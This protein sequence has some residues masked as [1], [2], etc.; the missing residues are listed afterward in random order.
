MFLSCFCVVAIRI[1]G[2][3]KGKDYGKGNGTPPLPPSR[4]DCCFCRCSSSSPAIGFF[5]MASIGRGIKKSKNGRGPGTHVGG[6]CGPGRKAHGRQ[7]VGQGLPHGWVGLGG[8]GWMGWVA[9]SPPA[10]PP[11]STCHQL[12]QPPPQN[13]GF[14]SCLI[15]NQ[16][17]DQRK[18]ASLLMRAPLTCLCAST[19]PPSEAGSGGSTGPGLG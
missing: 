6:G 17:E 12:E 5:E 13:R 1:L 2:K 8:A 16:V 15:W 3:G 18:P 7:Q 4:G 10:W 11:P 14:W 9:P 19:M